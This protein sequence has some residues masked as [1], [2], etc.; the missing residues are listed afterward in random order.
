MT[1]GAA[2]VALPFCLGLVACQLDKPADEPGDASSDLSAPGS[3]LRG[4]SRSALYPTDWQPE[5]RDAQGRFLHDFSFAGYKNGEATPGA[6][7][8]AKLFDVVAGYGGDATGITNAGPAIQAAL[9][10]AGAAGGGVVLLPAGRYRVDGVLSVK[11]PGVVVRGAGPGKTELYFTRA[12]GMSYS[13]H[14]TFAGDVKTGELLPLAVEGQALSTKLELSDAKSLTVGDDLEV[15]ITITPEFVEEHRMT[16]IWMVAV[17]KW[18]S[19]FRRRVVAVDTG[20]TPPEVTL[21]VPLRS[22]LKLR[23]QAGVRRS[24]GYLSGCG[25]ESLSISNAVAAADAWKEVQVQAVAMLGVKDCWVRDVQSFPSPLA[26]AAGAHLQSGGLII[27]DSKRVTVENTVFAKAQNRGEGGAGYLFDVERSSEILIKDATGSEGRHN[28][29]QNWD[30]GASGIVF[31]RIRSTGGRAYKSKDDPLPLGAASEFH[32]SLAMANLIDSATLDDGWNAHN[33]MYYSSGAGHSATE[34][35]FWNCRGQG[36]IS[37]Y[38]YGW[39]YVIGADGLDVRTELPSLSAAGTEPLDY[40]ESLGALVEP[41]SLY[42]D[43][44]RRRLARAGGRPNPERP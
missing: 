43:Q 32:H 36:A 19:L 33:R 44:L 24:T 28:F 27:A 25:L 37:S 12:Q 16:G 9:D 30:F 31:L 40:V 35:V 13:A 18:R 3:D 11:K 34:S 26:A 42:E 14:L 38:Q 2:R 20:K 22:R 39:G 5:F 21:D 1:A 17:G 29:I 23:D 6:P 4:A 10:A 15:G 7:A 41:S 8:D